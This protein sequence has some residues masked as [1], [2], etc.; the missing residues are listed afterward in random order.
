MPAFVIVT[1][2]LDGASFI[3]ETLDSIT[4]QTDRDWIHYVV[5]G[6]STDG[7]LDIVHRSMTA[8]P[9]R[10]L[11]EGRD[12]G[13]YDAVF[14]GFEAAMRNG[15]RDSRTP[16]CWINADDMLMPWALATIRHAFAATDAD[17]ITTLPC[18][19]DAAGRLRLVSP[20]AWHPRALIR[21]GLFHGRGL[22]W[23]QQESTFFTMGLFSRV[24]SAVAEKIRSTRLSGDFLLWRE[25]ARHGAP[26]AVPTAV[27]GFRSHGGNA[28]SKHMA[29]YFTELSVAGI[30]VPPALLGRAMRLLFRPVALARAAID[31]RAEVRQLMKEERG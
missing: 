4:R 28:S 3:A 13:L 20:Y 17:W 18:H 29:D 1:P 27:S 14:K 31:F 10:R 24:D 7:T 11:L 30:R 2:V 19:W 5:D 25:F 9:R 26:R 16:C 23:I 15:H 22:G 21:A 6:G 8:E 12:K